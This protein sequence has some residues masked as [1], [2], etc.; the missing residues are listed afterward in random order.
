MNVLEL[1]GLELWLDQG[2]GTRAVMLT[3][4][5]ENII[6]AACVGAEVLVKSDVH[7]NVCEALEQLEDRL[8]EEAAAIVSALDDSAD[9][10]DDEDDDDD[11]DDDDD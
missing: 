1:D 11:D 10:D 6:A 8:G 5:G 7:E 2:A 3:G 9:D 4:D